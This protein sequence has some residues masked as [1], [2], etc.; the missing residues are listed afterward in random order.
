M[1][2]G[3][4]PRSLVAFNDPRLATLNKRRQETILKTVKSVRFASN[5]EVHSVPNVEEDSKKD[6]WASEV[7]TMAKDAFVVADQEEKQRVE[8]Y[9]NAMLDEQ[10]EQWENGI[11]DPE[12]LAGLSC[13]LSAR[14]R[15]LALQS[16]ALV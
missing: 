16:A 8:E 12:R 5:V 3:F 2:R 14:S 6:V 9:L 1:C 13:S 10:I 4:T 15:D 11:Y 7:P